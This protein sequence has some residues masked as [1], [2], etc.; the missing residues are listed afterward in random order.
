MNS[1]KNFVIIQSPISIPLTLHLDVAFRHMKLKKKRS[2]M[3]AG[4]AIFLP[5]R[6]AWNRYKYWLNSTFSLFG[7][8]IVKKRTPFS[9]NGRKCTSS[10]VVFR[11][12]PVIIS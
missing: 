6:M 2:F 12:A 1:Y 11:P 5:F 7:P 10:C 3:Q 8:S 9:Q 4:F